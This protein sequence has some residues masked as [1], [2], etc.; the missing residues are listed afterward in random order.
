MS[1]RGHLFNR[2]YQITAEPVLADA[3]RFRVEQALSL[4]S[5]APSG[6]A[7]A[8][9][10]TAA[11]P[12]YAPGTSGMAGPAAAGGRAAPKDGPPLLPVHPPQ[13]IAQA[14]S[15]PGRRYPMFAGAHTEDAVEAAVRDGDVQ[16]P[17]LGRVAVPR[18]GE[19]AAD[20]VSPAGEQLGV[21]RLEVLHRHSSAAIMEASFGTSRL[22]RR[23]GEMMYDY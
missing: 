20:R 9:A 13:V 10:V 16:Q 5:G 15:G 11:P 4:W 1:G 19:A 6:H 14:S 7:P 12:S 18:L 2:M 17:G 23:A 21:P 3:A 8:T 22:W